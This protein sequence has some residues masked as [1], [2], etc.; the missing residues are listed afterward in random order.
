MLAYFGVSFI[1]DESQKISKATGSMIS[2]SDNLFNYEVK[3]SD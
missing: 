3:A 1:N 2:R